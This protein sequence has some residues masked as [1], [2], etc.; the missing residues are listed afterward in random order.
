MTPNEVRGRLKAHET[1][2]KRKLEDMDALAWAVGQYAA[3]GFHQ[4]KKYP[5]KP[6]FVKHEVPITEDM[7]PE[8]VKDALI[9]YAEIH[10]AIERDKYGNHS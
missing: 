4:P 9:S 3:Q 6:Q 2:L 8:D 5:E 1:A 7:E 10:N